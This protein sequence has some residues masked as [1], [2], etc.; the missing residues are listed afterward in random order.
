MLESGEDHDI[1]FL[2]VQTSDGVFTMVNHNE[3]NGYYGGF[4]VTCEVE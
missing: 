3:H 4:L 1:A 2:L